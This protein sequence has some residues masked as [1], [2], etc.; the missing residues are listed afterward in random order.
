M[1]AKDK[2]QK[3]FPRP[4]DNLLLLDYPN[5]GASRFVQ[6][7]N[8]ERS[9]YE[10]MTS[11]AV[12]SSA[13][14]AYASNAINTL[15]PKNG[16]LM[17]VLPG[18]FYS[19]VVYTVAAPAVGA[20]T[21]LADQIRNTEV[22]DGDWNGTDMVYVANES[23]QVQLHKPASTPFWGL[24]QMSDGGWIDWTMSPFDNPNPDFMFAVTDNDQTGTLQMQFTMPANNLSAAAGLYG[25]VRFYTGFIEYEPLTIK[26]A[27]Y[28]IIP[29]APPGQG[30]SSQIAPSVQ[31]GLGL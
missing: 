17:L 15:I 27:T 4:K 24:D 9:S 14:S 19:P 25:R 21:V 8:I 11:A 20:A 3:V 28:T 16:H 23:L 1:Q 2:S 7:T 13:V 30:S 29:T 5:R 12:T 18:V 22:I 10:Y 26:P 31:K 6:V